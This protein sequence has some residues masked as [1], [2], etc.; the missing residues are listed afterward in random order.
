M[1]KCLNNYY[2][3]NLLPTKYINNYLCEFIKKIKNI[4]LKENDKFDIIFMDY[5]ELY[6]WIN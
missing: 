6:E 1:K 3:I 2:N 4:R 5:F